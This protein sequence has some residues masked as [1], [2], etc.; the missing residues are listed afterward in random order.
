[1]ALRKK[2]IAKTDGNSGMRRIQGWFCAVPDCRCKR[3]TG[4]LSRAVT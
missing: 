2:A 3:K 4:L 1:M